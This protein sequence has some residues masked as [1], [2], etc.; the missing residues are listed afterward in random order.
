MTD[1]YDVKIILSFDNLLM[2]KRLIMFI[3]LF[4]SF[5]SNVSF[6]EIVTLADGRIVNL[7]EDGTF[8]IISENVDNVNTTYQ[9][10]IIFLLDLLTI[11]YQSIEFL[12]GSKI[13]LENVTIDDQIKIGQLT[14]IGLNKGYFQNFNIKKFD[15]YKGKLFEKL[16]VKNFSLGQDSGLLQSIDLLEINKLD[17]KKIDLLKKLAEGT[18]TSNAE[19]ILSV[20]DSFS[21]DKI[22]LKKYITRIGN[23]YG[24][25]DSLVINNFSNF[26]LGNLIYTGLIY[27]QKTEYFSQLIKVEKFEIKDLIFNRPSDYNIDWKDFWYFDDPRI[28]F[29]FFNSVRSIKTIGYYQENRLLG[30]VLTTD[31]S[32]IAD[33]QTKKMDGFSIPVSFKAS[34]KG[35][36]ITNINN[37]FD[38]DFNKLNYDKLK[39]DSEL[40]V[41]WNTIYNVFSIQYILA[42]QKGFDFNLEVKIEDVD[43]NLIS[44]IPSPV[45]I[46]SLMEGPKIKK[47]EIS[48]QDKG[49]AERLLNYGASNKNMTKTE[50][51]NY[52]IS[53]IRS[54]PSTYSFQ[55]DLVLAI[56]NFIKQ[57]DKI[58]FSI[59]PPTS[60][61]FA[62]I[63]SF[64]ASPDVLVELLNLNIK[65]N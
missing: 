37:Y 54:D 36:Q 57:P 23:F 27:D 14:L 49:L 30:I 26:S 58:T 16:I 22:I 56:I 53:E 55:S 18:S 17:I 63:S 48:V 11:D 3:F 43:E 51:V 47:F 19:N 35:T 42:M 28:F 6:S 15:S 8:T 39:F 13:V 44:L 12:E 7:N 9:N 50:F 5:I 65:Y 61:S 1:N 38:N 52:I 62:D 64:I 32:E 34:S 4:V 21:V 24:Y 10:S 25:L 40:A 2:K 31:E 46:S 20:I 59:N 45:L 33:F 60:L 41:D 29:S